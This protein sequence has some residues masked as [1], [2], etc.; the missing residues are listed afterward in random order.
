MSVQD[1][2]AP[3]VTRR[4][5]A[6]G[7]LAV[8][9]AA[10]MAET[11]RAATEAQLAAAPPGPKPT[12]DSGLVVGDVKFRSF[13]QEIGGYRAYPKGSPKG[14]PVIVCLPMIKGV[15]F[16]PHRDMVRRLAREGFYVIM[17]D[18]WIR[19]GDANAVPFPQLVSTLVADPNIAEQQLDIDAAI[20]FAGSEGANTKK[21]G[22]FGYDNGGRIIYRYLA[23]NPK[24][25]A[26][27]VYSAPTEA[28]PL[29]IPGKTEARPTPIELAGGM[30]G[31]ILAIYGDQE[32]TIKPADIENMK[33]ALT[34]AGDT[35]SKVSIYPG[36]HGFITNFD[37]TEESKK[38]WAEGVAWLKSHGLKA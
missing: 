26:G 13:D 14:L 5:L 17:P 27:V 31:R 36:K 23:M 35:K 19:K 21:L 6:L 7:G 4:A 25:V 12:D 22:M 11:A 9:G 33:A 3:T 2:T 28:T 37:S 24:V 20:A 34:K 1:E 18:L 32:G 10:L 15:N 38:A 30:K 16:P 8:A 29:S